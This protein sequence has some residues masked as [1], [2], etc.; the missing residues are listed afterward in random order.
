MKEF[1]STKKSEL[2]AHIREGFSEEEVYI[3]LRPCIDVVVEL[4]ENGPNLEAIYCPPS[5][6]RLTSRRVTAALE[7]V[8]IKLL[9]LGGGAGRPKVYGKDNISEIRKLQRIGM[10]ITRIAEELDIPRRTI[11]HLL[12]EDA[13]AKEDGGD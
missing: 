8:G 13:S 4:L 5:L 9:P 6:H 7:Q 3:A 1:K 11:Y 12:K 2:I 10:P